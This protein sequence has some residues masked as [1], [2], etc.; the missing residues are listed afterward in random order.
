MRELAG[1]VFTLLA[2]ALYLRALRG[3]SLAAYRAA[4]LATLA[5]FFIKYNYAALWL[6]GVAVHQ[7]G[8]LPAATRAA[9]GRW[10][11]S[12]MWP[13]PTRDPLRA[14]PACVLYALGLLA[15]VG[16]GLG[17]ALY[18]V[19][20]GVTVVCVW[21]LWRHGEGVRARWRALPPPARAFFET[22]VAPLWLWA[23]IPSPLHVRKLMAFLVNRPPGGP[24][25]S[26]GSPAY[27]VRS[28]VQD[29]AVE[30]TLGVVVLVAA[31]V[32]AVGLWRAGEPYRVLILV[33]VVEVGAVTLHPY[34][35]V[36]FLATAA[37]L[38][39][40]L[41]SLGSTR[42]AIRLVGPTR[43]WLVAGAAGALTLALLVAWLPRTA[44]AARLAAEYADNSVDP[45]LAAPLR[46]LDEQAPREGRVAVI[47]AFA[48]LS[49]SLIRWTLARTARH[50]PVRGGQVGRAGAG[51]RAARAGA[52]GAGDWVGRRPPDRILGIR[53]LPS[54]PYHATDDFQRFN[55]WQ[56]RV[57]D[58]VSADRRWRQTGAQRFPESG[59]EVVVFTP[60]AP[61]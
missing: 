6:L 30:S 39:M 20:V 60:A 44:A 25:A 57:L 41:A 58:E 16:R 45:A 14:A 28:F 51:R 59:L 50:P 61:G 5:L 27:Y 47:G 36:R 21:R 29:Y 54:S 37:P 35:A 24:L 32:A 42:A 55:A 15:L 49:P 26:V 8:R 12:R 31:A 43:G 13:W 1:V 34:Q 19:V 4:G 52:T 48:T 38:L 7:V 17:P 23:L 53:V 40:L 9:L 10:V 2:L 56:G 22:V 33:A 11:V 3:G 46:Y 18:A